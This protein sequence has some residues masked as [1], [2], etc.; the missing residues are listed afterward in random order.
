MLWCPH[1]D[2]ILGT[3][4]YRDELL[5]RTQTAHGLAAWRDHFLHWELRSRTN[6]QRGQTVGRQSSVAREVLRS[7]RANCTFKQTF[8]A[9]WGAGRAKCG[10]F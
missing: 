3:R 10:G 6:T 1:S 5:I 7:S 2:G 4:P 9:R 8:R